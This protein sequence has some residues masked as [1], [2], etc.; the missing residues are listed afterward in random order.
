SPNVS[1]GENQQGVAALGPIWHFQDDAV[2]GKVDV[3][4]FTNSA[5][6]QQVAGVNQ[7]LTTFV[8]QNYKDGL[9]GPGPIIGQFSKDLAFELFTKVPEPASV[10]LMGVALAAIA[11]RRRRSSL[12]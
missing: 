12:V 7:F 3:A 9:D 8:P 10:G 6:V 4:T 2:S 11:A 1:P 5:G